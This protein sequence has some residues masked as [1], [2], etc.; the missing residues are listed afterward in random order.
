MPQLLVLMLLWPLRHL[1]SFPLRQADL[2]ARPP[3]LPLVLHLPRLHL[4]QA[5]LVR[6]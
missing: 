3:L 5:G 6:T 4:H 2:A 1:A